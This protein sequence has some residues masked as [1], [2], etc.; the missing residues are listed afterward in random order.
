MSFI[1][2]SDSLTFTS[3]VSVRLWFR[4]IKGVEKGGTTLQC[5]PLCIVYGM[6]LSSLF[7][8]LG[9]GSFGYITAEV[10]I[11]VLLVCFPPHRF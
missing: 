9:C 4:K 3:I 11:Q 2:K 1:Y 10:G 7:C 5:S 8:I 6:Y